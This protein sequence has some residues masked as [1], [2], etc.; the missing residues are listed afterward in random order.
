MFV[1]SEANDLET[2]KSML[3]E[4]RESRSLTPRLEAFGRG[5]FLRDAFAGIDTR[6]TLDA[7]LGWLAVDS[8]P[9]TLRLDGGVGYLIENRFAGD[10]L[11][12]ALAQTV[13]KYRW[14]FSETTELTNDAAF[15]LPLEEADAWRYA[16]TLAIS[17]ALSRLFSLKLSHALSYL[18]GPVPGFRKTDTIVSAALVAKFA[19]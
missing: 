17:A 3:A 18:N 4:I 15:V 11:R 10:D 14:A 7:G 13:A 1:R 16:N 9:H 6:V 8:A 19:R 2:A 5:G 12:S